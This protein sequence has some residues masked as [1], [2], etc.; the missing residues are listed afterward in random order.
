MG[1]GKRMKGN[2]RKGNER[3]GKGFKGKNQ[4]RVEDDNTDLKARV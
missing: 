3:E 4:T 2:E 1:K